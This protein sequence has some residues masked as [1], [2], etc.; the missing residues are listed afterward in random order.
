MKECKAVYLDSFYPHWCKIHRRDIRRCIIVLQQRAETA[1]RERDEA[2]HW[3][4]RS[5]QD[6][7]AMSE[8]SRL[9]TEERDALYSSKPCHCGWDTLVAR[10]HTA[11]GKVGK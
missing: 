5:H 4:N 1:E 3:H 6:F 10:Y 2:R 9:H 11:R 7:L 8:L